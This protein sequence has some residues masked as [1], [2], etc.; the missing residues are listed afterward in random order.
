MFN[1][2]KELFSTTINEPRKKQL[3]DFEMYPPE[4]LKLAMAGADCDQLPGAFGE[5]GREISNPVP[6]NGAKG[7]IKY[8]AKLR[9]KGGLP[10]LFHRIGSMSSPVT[11]HSV[12][13]YELLRSDDE[14]GSLR[15]RYDKWDVLYLDMYHPRR[16]ELAPS[17]YIFTPYDSKMGIDWP[18]GFGVNSI[19]DNFPHGLPAA[20]VEAWGEESLVRTFAK[21]LEKTLSES[22]VVPKHAPR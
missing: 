16:S 22:I 12:D 11:P 21:K 4:F 5:F 7:E 10:V 19:V 20:M 18:I 9:G 6:V 2:I 8:L 1:F 14:S 3:A 13:A 15:P 17:N